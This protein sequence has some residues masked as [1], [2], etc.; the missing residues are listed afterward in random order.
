MKSG[1]TSIIS[2]HRLYTNE[3]EIFSESDKF[4]CHYEYYKYE[5]QSF[6]IFLKIPKQKVL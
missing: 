4:L 6:G 2:F 1:A 5:N 3:A